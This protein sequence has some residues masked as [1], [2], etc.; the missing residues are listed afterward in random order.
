MLPRWEDSKEATTIDY[1]DTIYRQ[2]WQAFGGDPT[3]QTKR[4]DHVTSRMMLFGDVDFVWEYLESS[5]ESE[6]LI[7]GINRSGNT[8][9][10]YVVCERYPAI[11]HLLLARGAELNFQTQEGRTPLMEAALW[12]RCENVKHR[13]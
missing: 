4:I 5:Q 8:A 2:L 6:F 7:H 10:L 9:L 1:R 11:V 3:C 12:G 13:L